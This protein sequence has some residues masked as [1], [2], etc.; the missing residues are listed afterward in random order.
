[1]EYLQGNL[2]YLDSFLKTNI[3]E[4]RLIRPEGTYIPFLDCRALKMNAKGLQTFFVNEAKVAMDGGDWFGTGG[5]GFMRMNIA[6]PR[7]LLREG[8]ERIERAVKT[9]R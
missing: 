7:A 6:T 1:M 4:I 2:E 9:L 8:L 5:E 3:P